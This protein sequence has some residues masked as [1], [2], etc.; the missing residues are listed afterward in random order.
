MLF[1][2]AFTSLITLGLT[3]GTY[4]AIGPVSDLHIV[5]V[6]I[7]PDGFTRPAVLAG[8]TFPGP[9]IQ[10]KKVIRWNMDM[11]IESG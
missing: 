1:C 4:A 2:S 5:D 7:A 9:L 8:G 10:A 11:S 3:I 6:D